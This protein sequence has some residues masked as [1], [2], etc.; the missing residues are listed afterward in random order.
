M[1]QANNSL[2]LF[3]NLLSMVK[4]YVFLFIVFFGVVVGVYFVVL[5]QNRSC[6]E[7]SAKTPSD[8][9]FRQRAFPFSTINHNAYLSAG[10]T[11]KQQRL[12]MRGG[13]ELAWEFAGP[14]NIE[15]RITDI[16]IQQSSSGSIF[17]GSASGGVFK[18][19]D[20]GQNWEAIFD[21]ET[22][23][24]I[25]DIAI[26]PSSPEIIYVGTG[27]ANAGGGSLAYD[28]TGIFK[29]INSGG[30]W[31]NIGLEN[32]GSIGRMVVHPTNP[33]IVYVAAMGRLF[34]DGSQ[35]GVFKTID[36]GENWEQ[37]LF[38][39]DSTGAID[40]VVNPLNPEIIYA[41][42]WERVR[43]P[44]RRSYGGPTSGIFKSIDGGENWLEL[45]N[46]LPNAPDEKGRIG[47]DISASSPNVVYAVYADSIGYFNGVYKSLNSGDSWM[48]V[49]NGIDDYVFSSFGW[50]FGRIKV[51]PLDYN[52]AYL[53]G[54]YLH[55]TNNGG[56]SWSDLPNWQMHVDQHALAIDPSSTNKIYAGNDGGFYS[57][58]NGGNNWNRNGN[59][60][61]TQF[62]TCELDE[63]F[64][65]RIYGG[66]QDNGTNRTMTGLLDD[67][68][69]IY[70][71]DGFR[72]LVD[73]VDN[74]FIYA[75]YQYGG[76][77]RSTNGG[78]SF[79]P[80]QD[81]ISLSDR[82]NWNCPIVFD[83]INPQ[84][85]YF[86]SNKLYISTDRAQSWTAISGDLTNGNEPGNI[87]YNTLSTIS[88]SPFNTNI[89][90]TGS[91]DGSV[92]FTSD[93]GGSWSNIS[94]GLPKRWVSS[95]TADY[96]VEDVVYVTFSGYRWDD[97]LPHVFR[98]SNNGQTWL[99]ISSNLPEAPVNE[100]VV[101][102]EKP[103]YLYV[104]T[105]FGVY[106]S[107]NFGENWLPAATQMPM[108]VVND[109]RIHNPARKLVAA[110]YGRGIYTLDL[111][112]L[113]S[114]ET[115]KYFAGNGL[116]CFPN[117]FLNEVK[118]VVPDDFIGKE[119]SIEIVDMKGQSVATVFR[120]TIKYASQ[121]IVWNAKS[122]YGN[123]MPKG[124]Y[125]VRV[126]SATM[127]LSEKLITY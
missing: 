111:S 68:D 44:G 5:R 52:T 120:G 95:I 3:V 99:D 88:V 81:G 4:R 100:I 57:S 126:V 8:Y 62:Y 42:M 14:T 71:G 35:G 90:Y 119:I 49:D 22:S 85:L 20:E 63:Q 92:W 40:I 74:N 27:E 117:P 23:L 61:I 18:T 67:W 78:D 86:G 9:F 54:L 108:V 48:K 105:D 87:A 7:E 75:E 28:G 64:P 59:L 97:Y 91:D 116:N 106:Y 60:P 53:I 19:N 11:A 82:F 77:G 47:I 6:I 43:R 10:K 89:I 79:L 17:V 2:V 107:N 65:E 101:D 80:A 13:D 114:V 125:F 115:E 109:L 104:A 26:S 93:G 121:E 33:D 112:V 118:I 31:E 16:E 102:P 55:K 72:V 38:I 12:D 21:D 98:S 84:T 103:G 1:L 58:A 94:N 96:F 34:A 50:W 15:G 73:P 24:S 76:V 113:T 37:K 122:N 124:I 127:V 36:G 51:D 110:T 66:T 56:S 45:T 41:A 32:S 39:S 30:T 46:G 25:G 123:K 29:S 70:G 69:R 83:P